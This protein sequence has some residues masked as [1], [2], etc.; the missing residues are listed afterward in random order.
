MIVIGQHVSSRNG[1]ELRPVQG[2]AQHVE[3]GSPGM[4]AGDSIAG[5]VAFRRLA[6][7]RPMQFGISLLRGVLLRCAKADIAQLLAPRRFGTVNHGV[8]PANEAS[9]LRS[10]ECNQPQ[11]RSSGMPCAIIVCARPPTRFI[12]SISNTRRPCW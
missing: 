10:A 6:V 7:E 11:P 5:A 4:I 2:A 3:P 12:A 9:G 8:D 1:I